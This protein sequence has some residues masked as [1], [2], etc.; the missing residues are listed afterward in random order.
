MRLS[1]LLFLL[2]YPLSAA[3]LLHDFDRDGVMEKIVGDAKSTQIFQQDSSGKWTLADYT[4]PEGVRLIDE[5][6]K[7][8]GL[9]WI[10][11]NEDG[12]DDL[13]FSNEKEL[14]IHLWTKEVK[15]ALGWTKGW[16]QTIQSGVRKNPEKDLPS[17]VGK[18]VRAEQGKLLVESSKKQ[19]ILRDIV[20]FDV[21]APKSPQEALQTFQVRS[22][23][24]VE[25]VASEPEVVDPIAMDW[26]AEGNLWVVEMR[27][28]PSGI[29]GK[30]KPGGVIKR[31][32]DK[33]GNGHYE[34]S[35]AFLEGLSYPT[36]VF[37]WK[38]GILI[39]APPDILYAEDSDGDGK[40][41]KKDVLF[42]GFHP[43]NQQHLV[44]GFEWGLDGWIYVANGDSGGTVTSLKTGKKLSIQGR[45]FRFKPDTGEMETV[46]AQSQFGLRRDDWGN[47]FGN[48]NSN[49]I[50]H[51]MMPEHYLRRNPQLAIKSVRNSLA[52]Y[53]G[54]TQVYPTSSVIER[55]NQPWSLNH[56]TSACSP[57]FYRDELFGPD[58]STS[59]FISE[60]V[61]NLVHRE[62]LRPDGLSFS[63]QRAQ[64]EEKQEFLSS[65]DHWFRPTGLKVG[66]DGAL[67]IAD[68]YRFVVEHPEWISPEMQA[69]LDIRIGEDKG[70]IYRVIPVNKPKRPI[71]NLA[72]LASPALLQAMNHSS[73]WQ[74]DTVMQALLEHKNPEIVEGLSTLIQPRHAP[75]VRIQALATLGLLQSLTKEHLIQAFGDPHAAVRIEALRQ[76]DHFQPKEDALLQAMAALAKDPEITVRQQLAFSLGE[77][78]EAKK[79]SLLQELGQTETLQ[80][81]VLSSLS[82]EN[83]YFKSLQNKKKEPEALPV[84]L[85]LK[86]SSPDRAEVIRKYADLSSLKGDAERGRVL[87]QN[88]C[89]ICHTYRGTGKPLGP[90]LGMAATKTVDWLLNAILDPNQ[91]VESRYRAWNITLTSGQSLVGTLGAETANNL[92]LQLPGG[93]EHA[94]LRQ[95]IAKQEIVLLSL[96]PSGLESV[97]PPQSMADLIQWLRSK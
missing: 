19:W 15:P 20:T 33:D 64:G 35:Q 10:D 47:W 28:Y 48:N 32:Q 42:T 74:R 14:S 8:A 9:R 41:D 75:H 58:F 95:D 34:S 65:S 60:P 56:V 54:A 66:P 24:R 73:G 92:V 82:P 38:K 37:A 63:S 97:L 76:T 67:Y 50:W 25:L 85:D 7:D 53:E 88:L 40:A 21:P 69:R 36:G 83:E 3:E 5:T 29:D 26:D 17:F 59:M 18:K 78:P 23:F 89:S 16:S 52:K 55:P 51:V 45:D 4:L 22:G 90:D 39:T 94:I 96:M 71:P 13:I 30:G 49:W 44:N 12:F 87:F 1:L 2:S 68:M 86:P 77:W 81:A 11:L 72:Q 84:S 57:I 46:S 93:T 91:I 31:L 43:G 27:D 80:L 70:R 61:H 79:L 6:G 62:V